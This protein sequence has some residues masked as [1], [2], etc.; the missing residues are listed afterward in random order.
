MTGAFGIEER[1]EEQLYSCK[2]PHCIYIKVVFPMA[3]MKTYLRIKLIL[4][5]IAT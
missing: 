2:G 4:I 3:V 1:L 5:S